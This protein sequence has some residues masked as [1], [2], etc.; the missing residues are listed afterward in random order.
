MLDDAARGP[1]RHAAEAITGTVAQEVELG[2]QRIVRLLLTLALHVV[3]T[4]A[5]AY[6]RR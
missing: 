1:V 3:R 2:V 5:W 6:V 4:P